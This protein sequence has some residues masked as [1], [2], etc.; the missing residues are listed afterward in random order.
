MYVACGRIGKLD[1]ARDGCFT[2]IDVFRFAA[3]DLAAR[4]MEGEVRALLSA[5]RET[6]REFLQRA[7][8]CSMGRREYFTPS[9]LTGAQ[10]D[11]KDFLR[12]LG[13]AAGARKR[14]A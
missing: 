4:G 12:L 3:F 10:A 1:L 9:H 14:T 13:R 7:Y 5:G 2:A 6:V 11:A 8:G